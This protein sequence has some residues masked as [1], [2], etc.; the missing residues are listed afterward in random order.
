MALGVTDKTDKS[1]SR[2]QGISRE[3][4]SDVLTEPTEDRSWFIPAR[5]CPSTP[6]GTAASIDWVCCAARRAFVR[7]RDANGAN[8]GNGGGPGRTGLRPRRPVG[9]GAAF[10]GVWGPTPGAG[11]GPVTDDKEFAR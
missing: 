8:V 7:L 11:D 2:R 3:H 9:P 4:A 6:A 1:P 5:E 10:L